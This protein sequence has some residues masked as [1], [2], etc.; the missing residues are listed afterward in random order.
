[1]TL[2]VFQAIGTGHETSVAWPTHAIGH[3]GIC[4]IEHPDGTI[5]TPSGWTALPGSPVI[6]FGAV[7]LS[8]FYRFATSAAEANFAITG[9]VDHNW[10]VIVTYTGV[11]TLNPFHI[12]SLSDTRSASSIWWFPGAQTFLDD[13]MVLNVAGWLADTAG[14]LSSAPVNADLGSLTE[15]YDAGTITGNGG[16]V[17]I[18]DGTK[19]TK[20]VFTFTSTTLTVD[21]IA[22]VA[23]LALQAADKTF[24]Q[25]SLTVNLGRQAMAIPC[26]QST[27][28]SFRVF[29]ADSADGKTGKTG[30]T[31]AVTLQK[32]GET[33][34]SSIAP[35][36]TEIG[37]GHYNIALSTTHMNT[38]GLTSLRATAT[39]ADP[40]DCPNCIDVI[41]YDKTSATRGTSG[42]A[43][44]AVAAEAA[45]GLH[46]IGTG[47][48]QINVAGGRA[49]ADVKFF[50]GTVAPA[51]TV[52]GIPKAEASGGSIA[53][54]SGAVGSVTGAVGSVT[55]NVGGNVVGTVASVVGAVGSVVGNV[56]GNVVGTVASV[57]GNVG[58][59]VL[60]TVASV[61]GNVGGNIVGSVASV[62]GA[63]GSI[64]ANGIARASW[65][66][67]AKDVLGEV[68][69]FTAAAGSATTVT[70]D[71]G[72][73]IVVDYYKNASLLCVGGTG[74]N[75]IASVSSYSAARVATLDRTVTTAFDA[76]SVFELRASGGGGG[77]TAT[78][79][80]DAILDY[81]YRPGRTLRGLFRRLGS[82]LEKA[83]GL[84]GSLVSY[85]QPDGATEE[86][87]VAQNPTSGTREVGT[88]TNSE[89][90]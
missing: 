29:T 48:G 20:G 4:C 67:D 30:L 69:R 45:G 60:G 58:G 74:I 13:C 73:S 32:E 26:K 65:A 86:F 84:K 57:V 6:A 19:P 72:A 18:I 34:F 5:T 33:S 15:R 22:A 66:Q 41:A 21:S 23:T 31:L 80:R 17:M 12:I 85:F 82:V 51:P 25:K 36:V 79:V 3:F 8:I 16:G 78:A 75:Q 83:T 62:V 46:T 10:G 14:P 1:M 55:G 37:S 39:G 53:S 24:G 59:N 88:V 87:T 49:D 54:V 28:Q 38:V 11:N 35:T 44:P 7:Q 47:A 71:A 77:A 90:P 56:G 76:T 89:T 50:G 9:S 43:L 2:P 70:F 64:A 42:T 61:V 68:R 27:A 52:A 81:A 40:A 63:V